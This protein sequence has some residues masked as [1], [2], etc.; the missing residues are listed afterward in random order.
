VS[1]STAALV[2]ADGAMT[3]MLVVAADITERKRVA[4]ELARR[5][6][7]QEAIAELGLASLEGKD[8]Q[9]LLDEAGRLVAERLGVQISGVF[10]LLPDQETLLLR[11]GEGWGPGLVGSYTIGQHDPSIAGYALR[12]GKSVTV[13]GAGPTDRFPS[14]PS[15]VGGQVVSGAATVV[16]GAEHPCGVLVALA[17]QACDFTGDDVG[18]LRS[19]AAILGLA[20]ERERTQAALRTAEEKYRSLVEEGPAIVY[21]HGAD[22]VPA[23]VTYISPQIVDLLG[24]GPDRWTEDPSFWPKVILRADRDRFTRAKG[25]AIERQQP[26]DVE[27]RIV[28]ADGREVWVQDRATLVR[29]TDGPPFYQ[30]V[31]V[32]ITARRRAEGERRTALDRQLRLATRLE[33]LHLVDREILSSTS[34]EEMASR[35]LDHL[36]LLVP[37][38]RGSVAVVEPGTERFSYAAVHAPEELMLEAD[39]ANV[40]P[41]EFMRDLLSRDVIVPDFAEVPSESP[42]FVGLR[43]LGLRSGLSIALRSDQR[44]EGTLILLSRTLNAFDDEALDIAREVGSQLAIAIGQMRLQETLAER[45]EELGRLADERQQMLHRIVRAQEEERER[46]ALELHDG[47]GQVLTSISLF[48]SDL[49]DEVGEYAR[50][51]A[52]RVNELIRR[53]IVDS[54][55]LVWSLRPPELERLGLVPA[56]R[57]LADETSGPALT[58]D[59][60]EEIGDTRFAPESEAVVYRVVQEAVHN[61]LKHAGASAISILL[62]RHDGH[63]TTLVED[64]GR[65]F[66][67]AGVQPGRGLGLIGMRERAEL[68]DGAL[69]VESAVEAGTRVRL[70]VPLGA[71]PPGADGGAS[72]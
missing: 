5:Q 60:H 52:V 41:D 21:L 27:Y 23:H 63:L 33:L 14:A 10:E 55:Q 48:A 72:Q 65:G 29:D 7:Q 64:N 39:L 50:P 8:L 67:P 30:G 3:G 66:D 20:I 36:R 11:S 15:L 6:R 46:V 43:K 44:Q 28:A 31:L 32:D 54:R 42:H 58:V 49:P 62:S 34:I 16:K 61:A 17:T 19:V 2:G 9:S 13:G 35:T 68:V 4:D 70:M 59:L 25:A 37:Y 69:V 38:D 18:F 47:L 71:T 12:V 26:L 1:L 56:L 22:A 51:R 57:R 24:Y 53:A 45:A 40:A